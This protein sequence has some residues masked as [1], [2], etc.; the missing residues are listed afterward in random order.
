[1]KKTCIQIKGELP[2]QATSTHYSAEDWP[3]HY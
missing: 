3:Y 1:M 2:D